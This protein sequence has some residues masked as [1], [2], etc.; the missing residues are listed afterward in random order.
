MELLVTSPTKGQFQVE[1]KG[2]PG[3]PKVGRGRT[4]VE[5]FG[6]FLIAYQKELGITEIDLAAP[7]AQHAEAARR[8]R[9]LSRR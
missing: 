3:S 2:A 7:E 8:K 5:A 9:E 6:D 4:L 1:P